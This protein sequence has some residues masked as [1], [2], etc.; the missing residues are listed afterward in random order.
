MKKRLAFAYYLF[1]KLRERGYL[2]RESL[3]RAAR[4]FRG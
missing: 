1:N 2:R 4:R 3:S